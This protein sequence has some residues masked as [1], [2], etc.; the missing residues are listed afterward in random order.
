MTQLSYM[1][2]S[3]DLPRV[4]DLLKHLA[5]EL[6]EQDA[7]SVLA[8]CSNWTEEYMFGSW[9]YGMT[10]SA[11]PRD[12]YAWRNSYARDARLVSGLTVSEFD[13]SLPLVDLLIAGL[14]LIDQAGNRVSDLSQECLAV[15]ARRLNQQVSPMRRLV[16]SSIGREG[17][18]SICGREKLLVMSPRNQLDLLGLDPNTSI[19][20]DRPWLVMQGRLDH[21]ACRA[22]WLAAKTGDDLASAAG[23]RIIEAPSADNVVESLEGKTPVFF[24]RDDYQELT[25]EKTTFIDTIFLSSLIQPERNYR[26]VGPAVRGMKDV[27][28]AISHEFLRGEPSSDKLFRAFLQLVTEAIRKESTWHPPGSLANAVRSPG[29]IPDLCGPELTN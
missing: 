8:K 14:F 25:G 15:T 27:Q 17:V 5:P 22:L 9:P 29:R 23:L 12:E 18:A 13:A 10:I 19:P 16:S 3:E 28:Y 11:R 1:L 2:R 21:V 7:L 26:N 4:N 20:D 24:C 6:S